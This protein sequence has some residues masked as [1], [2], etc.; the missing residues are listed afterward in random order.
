M[1]YSRS[2]M[3]DKIPDFISRKVQK[4]DYFFL[5]LNPI[6]GD[7]LTIIS[8]GIEICGDEYEVR[9]SNFPYYALEYVISGSCDIQVGRRSS[10][11]GPG[12]LFTYPPDTPLKIIKVGSSHLTKYF[13]SFVGVDALSLVKKLESPHKG[14]VD[15]SHLPWIAENFRQ[16]LEL[17]KKQQSDACKLLFRLILNQIPN[18]P[19]LK[20]DPKSPAYET[21]R[22]CRALIDSDYA[23]LMALSDLSKSVHVSDAYICRIFQKYHSEP[24]SKAITRRKMEQAAKLL[25]EGASLVKAVAGEVG[26]NDPYHFSRVFKTHYGVSPRQFHRR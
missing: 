26:Y 14:S 21:Y 15:L 23:K 1:E 7:S 4:G 3:T 18:E 5:N 17:G 2:P 16:L 9:R 19:I 6:N 22:K 24:P 13:V 20:R 8:G 12:Q 10:H 25:I 11:I